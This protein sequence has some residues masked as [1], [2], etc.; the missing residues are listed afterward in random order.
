M[1]DHV[2]GVN[3]KLAAAAPNKTK[4]VAYQFHK[5]ERG[6]DCVEL[7]SDVMRVRSDEMSAERLKKISAIRDELNSGTYL[8]PRKLDRALDSA[9]DA[10][11]AAR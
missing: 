7:S 2:T 10:L 4:I 5:A 11:L 3:Q 1:M 6:Q 8:T 9:L